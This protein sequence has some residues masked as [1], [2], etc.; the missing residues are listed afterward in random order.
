MIRLL[1]VMTMKYALTCVLPNNAVGPFLRI[2][3]NRTKGRPL[4]II[5]KTAMISTLRLLKKVMGSFR[6][7]KPPLDMVVSAC[8]TA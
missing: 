7:E 6:E 1:I 2:L 3:R 8:V 5:N 4:M